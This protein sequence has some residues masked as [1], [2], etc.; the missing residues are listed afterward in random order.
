MSGQDSS[1]GKVLRRSKSERMLFG[2]CGGAGQ[3]LGVDPNLLRLAIGILAVIGG[4]GIA[5]YVIG[6]L[7]IPEEGEERS[8]AQQLLNR[9]R[10]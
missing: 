10:E 3:Y 8:I 5:I 6:A 7:L 4:S 9:T 2:V 1:S